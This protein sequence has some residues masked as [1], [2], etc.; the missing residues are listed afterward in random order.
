[1][2]RWLRLEQ[3]LHKQYPKEKKRKTDAGETDRLVCEWMGVGQGDKTVLSKKLTTGTLL[4][5]QDS[6]VLRNNAAFHA[7]THGIMRKTYMSSLHMGYGP[8]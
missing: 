8:H 5:H 6:T 3:F 2:R 1:M 4:K 7:G